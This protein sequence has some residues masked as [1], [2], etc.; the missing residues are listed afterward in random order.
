MPDFLLALSRLLTSKVLV[1]VTIGI[2]DDIHNS[3]ASALGV[4]LGFTSVFIQG[5][6][7]CQE[8]SWSSRSEAILKVGSL[9]TAQ[10]QS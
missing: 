2:G 10:L 9:T 7:V 4:S 1:R 6:S 8:H 3:N 5:T